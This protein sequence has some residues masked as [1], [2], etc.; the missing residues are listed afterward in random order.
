VAVTATHAHGAAAWGI[1]RRDL[2]IFRTYRFRLVAQIASAFLSLALF[3]Y[4][5]RLVGERAFDSPDAYFAFVVVGLVALQTLTSTLVGVPTGVR[6]ELVAGTLERFLLSPFGAV[7]AI[8]SMSG[9]PFALS[10]ITGTL[11]LGVGYGVFGMPIV[12]ST[13]ALAVP[14]VALGALAFLPLSMLVCAAVFA[15]KQAGSAAAFVVTCLSLLAGA[16]FPVTLLPDWLEWMS[17]V[18]PLTPTLDLL[19]RVLVGNPL[20][21]SAWVDVLKLVGFAVVLLPVAVMVL[22]RSIASSQRRGT[23]TEY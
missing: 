17:E 20:D 22:R 8:A 12:W 18:Q 6:Q 5:S 3:Y 15:F 21:S 2:V 1:V 14:V 13:A 23:I 10:V 19:R 4:V 16:F 7:S 11:T 9:F